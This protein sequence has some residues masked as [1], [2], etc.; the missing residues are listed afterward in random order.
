MPKADKNKVAPKADAD[1]GSH[2]S[3]STFDDRSRLLKDDEDGIRAAATQPGHLFQEQNDDEFVE[4][5]EAMG[6]TC[7]H[8]RVLL[9]IGTYARAARHADEKEGWIR[10]VALIIMLYEGITQGLLDFDY[11]PNSTLVSQDNHRLAAAQHQHCS[12]PEELLLQLP[13]V[14]QC[15]PRRQICCGRSQRDG[16][17]ERAEA[18]QRGLSAYN[19]LPSVAEG[20]SKHH[21]T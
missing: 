11:A 12:S 8:A 5:L 7:N 17:C 20:S 4:E 19:R 2:A 10:Q 21:R 14:A 1:D 18:D 15:H 13:H 16:S 3:G 9:L 6:L